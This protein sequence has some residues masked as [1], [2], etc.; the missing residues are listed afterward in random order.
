MLLQTGS[1]EGQ[2]KKKTGN[3]VSLSEQQLVDCSSSYGN[4]GC[5]GGWV[6]KAFAYI[7]DIGGIEGETDYPY[8][9]QVSVIVY[10]W[11]VV[12]LMQS[13]LI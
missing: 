7:K 13:V 8:V 11:M 12:E 10:F 3:L 6:D 9:A 5:N 1:V 2:H 4:E